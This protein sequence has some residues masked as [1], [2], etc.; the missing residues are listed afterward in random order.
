MLD[1]YGQ[2]LLQPLLGAIARHCHQRGIKAN[3]LTLSGLLAGI[4]AAA[5]IAIGCPVVGVTVLWLSG[6]LD[7]ADGTLARLTRPSALGAVLDITSDRIV[8]VAVIVAL[9]WRYPEARFVLLLLTATIVVA[10]SLFLAIGAALAN[11]SV[12]SFHYAPGLAERTEGFIG[13]SLMSLDDAHLVQWTWL[14]IIVILITMA[15]RIVYVRAAL[16]EVS[17]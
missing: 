13:L 4:I 14:L 2:R 10:I 9:A 11:H 8:E 17:P 1:T 5:L 6:L 7:A 12:K 3:T 16:N 15:Q